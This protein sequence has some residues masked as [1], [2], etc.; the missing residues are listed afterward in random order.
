MKQLRKIGAIGGAISLALCWPLAVGQIGQNAITDGV[1]KLNN[2][3][4][5]AEIVEYD[6]GYLS[7]N[8]KTRL[9][10]TDDNLK[11]QLALDGLPSEFVVNSSVSHGLVSLNAL[12]TFENL[13]TLP[14]TLTTS[15]ELNGNTDFN[16]ELDQFNH[17]GSGE[18]G[19][20]VSVTKSTLSGHA[21]VLGQVDYTLSVPSVQ[22]DFETGEEATLSNL[23]GT[24]S[25]QQA[26][27]Y[28]LGSQSFTVERFLVS[29]ST[30]QPF[31]TI[32]NSQYDFESH[33][34][35]ETKRLRS[36]LKL[37]VENLETN[38]GQVNN[39]N[40]DFEMSKLD[41]QSFE[42][43]FEIYQ[44]SPVLTQEDVSK[45][46]P[47]IDI[48]FAKGFDLSMNNMSLALG[49]GDFQSNWLVS[50]PE[51]TE[52]ISNNP[53]TI[54]PA[55]TGNIHS[56]F[57]YELVEEYPFIREGI[58]ELIVM[59]MIKE[60]DSGYEISAE[61]ENGNLVFENG[62]EIPLIALLMPVF[63]Q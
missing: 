4:I 47:F 53:S 26:Q 61:L 21:T 24:G 34:D 31:M 28:W 50:V 39:L 29:D 19:T 43:I 9:T 55:L 20:S 12:S 13:E 48:L 3:S 44:S 49:K 52:N 16:F 56:S 40:V 57:S 60:T 15:T 42:K 23:K 10:V 38:D 30:M 1:A 62:Q 8:V 5:Q 22:I 27:G 37:G 51:G 11:Q 2:S 63:V 54:L 25:G 46:I 36:N 32:E 33:L 7:S 17:Q 14:L 45:I 59:E 18:N 6:R 58:D 35:E 41:S